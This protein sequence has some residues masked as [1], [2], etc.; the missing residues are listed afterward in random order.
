MTI[1]CFVCALLI[2]LLI[3]RYRIQQRKKLEAHTK[4]QIVNYL[5]EIELLKAQQMLQEIESGERSA[6]EKE[7]KGLNEY[8]VNPL[9]QRELEVLQ[10]ICEG[11]TNKQIAERMFVSVHTVKSHNR[12][13]FEKLDVRNRAQA[14]VMVSSFGFN[15][16]GKLQA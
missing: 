4:Q 11:L 12:H 1:C 13:I 9:T 10:L 14:M 8:L 15:G 5:N 7:E 6:Q 2:V 3:W 16:E